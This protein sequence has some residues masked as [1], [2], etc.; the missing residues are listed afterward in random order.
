MLR[1]EIEMFCSFFLYK[2]KVYQN[3]VQENFKPFERELI[4]LKKGEY[5]LYSK[6][7]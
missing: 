4:F 7:Y 5:S 3:S 2:A 6:C 1:D